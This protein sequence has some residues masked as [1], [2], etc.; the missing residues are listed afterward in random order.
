MR[1]IAILQILVW[2]LAGHC[3]GQVSSLYGSLRVTLVDASGAQVPGAAIAVTMP[4][5]SWTRTVTATAE[6]AGLFAQDSW[7]V[8]PWL[9]LDAGLRYD[10]ETTEALNPGSPGML[11]VFAALSL[12][13]SPPLDR[14]NIQPRVGFAYQALAGG[15]LTVRGSYGVFYDRLLNLA[16]YLSA[17]GD[18]VQ[19]TRVILPGGDAAGVFQSPAQKLLA[20]PG[21]YS[22]SGLIAFST[23]W[24][25][26]NTQQANFV[27]S[28]Q[29]RP[30]LTL[31]A[32]YVWVKGTYLPRSR[33]VNPTD[34]ERAAAFL[35]AGGTQP[36]LLHR[37]FFRPVSEVSEA[38][39]FEGSGS[40]TYH[41]LRLSLRGRVHDRPNVVPA[42][43]PESY[44][45]RFGTFAVPAL[46]VPGNVG[47]NAF[48]G[49]G[50]ASFN[51]R[52]QRDVRFTESLDCQFI[53]EAFNLFNRTNVRAVNPNYQRAGEALSAFDPRQIQLGL[54]LLF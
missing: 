42:A 4:E 18:G 41:G 24:E 34:S 36:E 17:V 16:T 32:G 49:P 19:M 31:E 47:R 35:A 40:S 53:A 48:T 25:L 21:G 15:R 6:P 9:T 46:G 54:R 28:S 20:Y 33:D 13:R 51:V 8:R 26:G 30:G 38:M 44:A 5:R 23:G 12:R 7:R 52:L 1:K 10:V 3:L 2:V 39:A 29:F 27:L 22:P 50:Y 43:S 11:P 14:N 45:T 37:N